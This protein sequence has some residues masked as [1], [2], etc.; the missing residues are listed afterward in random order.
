MIYVKSSETL[1]SLVVN[2]DK[3]TQET[4]IYV[5]TALTPS[6]LI[7]TGHSN[8]LIDAWRLAV[9]RKHTLDFSLLVAFRLK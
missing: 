9:C 4:T 5:V 3:T 8:F 6:D 1:W 2:N 7:I